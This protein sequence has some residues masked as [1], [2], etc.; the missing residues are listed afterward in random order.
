[1]ALG[2]SFQRKNGINY[3]NINIKRQLRL[4]LSLKVDQTAQTNPPNEKK[5]ENLKERILLKY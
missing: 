4:S 1:M 2:E 3:V 5:L